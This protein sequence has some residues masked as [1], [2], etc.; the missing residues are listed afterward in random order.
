[1]AF[2]D[3]IKENTQGTADS[4]A[5][6]NQEGKKQSPGLVSRAIGAVKASQAEADAVAKRN[7]TE[8]APTVEERAAQ[9]AQKQRDEKEA[10]KAT[11]AADAD[12]EQTANSRRRSRTR[13]VIG[14]PLPAIRPRIADE[15][16][17]EKKAKAS[18]NIGK[19]TTNYSKTVSGT[20]LRDETLKAEELSRQA[21]LSAA[22]EESRIR[23][24]YGAMGAELTETLASNVLEVNDEVDQLWKA[25]LDRQEKRMSAIEEMIDAGR[26]NLANP[27]AFFGSNDQAS[28]FG[29]GMAVA[30]GHLASALGG[31]PNTALKII[32]KAIERNLR[33]QEFNIQQGTARD[34]QSIQLLDKWRTL[35]KDQVASRTLAKINLIQQA[36][37][38]LEA[39]ALR[40]GSELAVQNVE[41]VKAALMTQ[42]AGLM[43]QYDDQ[44]KHSITQ[45]VTRVLPLAIQERDERLSAATR[46][47]ELDT[48]A[49]QGAGGQPTALS[50]ALGGRVAFDEDATYSEGV[51]AS[52]ASP[53]VIAEEGKRI[54]KVEANE[55]Y[56][57][58]FSVAEGDDVDK[59]HSAG[60]AV[61]DAAMEELEEIHDQ[62]ST[63]GEYTDHE[64]ETLWKNSPVL[65]A[66]VKSWADLRLPLEENRVK[67]GAIGMEVT[68]SPHLEKRYGKDAMADKMATVSRG[69]DYLH[70]SDRA[71]ELLNDLR[72]APG[73]LTRRDDGSV[74]IDRLNPELRRD[75][76]EYKQ[77]MDEAFSVVRTANRSGALQGP[78]E[79]EL[80]KEM[81]N[82]VDTGDSVVDLLFDETNRAQKL[83]EQHAMIGRM[84]KREMNDLGMKSGADVFYSPDDIGSRIEADQVR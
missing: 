71:F 57:Q 34:A 67:I 65:Q 32:D 51:P 13:D 30:T 3:F 23:S 54:R 40:M 15:T 39:Q 45:Q 61:R 5:K 75:Y 62:Q 72:R 58:A 73:G 19:K 21:T 76:L 6:G 28:G 82:L 68:I 26:N 43:R 25:A 69:V 18:A 79:A 78:G 8:G 27:A 46:P 55:V 2:S 12:T 33:A 17:E 38:S 53:E 37:F 59:A 47:T 80:F 77:L 83:S 66:S 29:A 44:Q 31:G 48:S 64:L 4:V 22:V 1:M 24:Q 42:K 60:L 63:G 36:E 50:T 7:R 20:Q 84:Y 35:T 11:Q 81:A 16:D 9:A 56:Q 52:I 41:K 74:D 10:I 14:V 49:A 70:A